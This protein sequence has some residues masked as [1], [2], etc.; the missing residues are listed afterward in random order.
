[1]PPRVTKHISIVLAGSGEQRHDVEIHRGVTVRDL[2]EQL[3]LAGHL[4]KL[5]DPAPLG[6]NEE[7]LSRIEDGEKLVLGPKTP[8]AVRRDS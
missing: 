5:G 4:S 8:V 6:E 2:L 7:I 1:M 3:N